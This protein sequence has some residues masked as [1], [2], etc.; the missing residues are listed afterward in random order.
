MFQVVA[1]DPDDP[2]TANG[3]LVYSLPED[4]TVIRRLFHLDPESGVLSTKVKLDRE[5]RSN[6][7]LI[8]DVS[9]LGSPPQQTST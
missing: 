7:T 8:L 6:Y 5:E 9:D 2:Q 1:S 4:G 3:K